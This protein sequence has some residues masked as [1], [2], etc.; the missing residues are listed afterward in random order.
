MLAGES[1]PLPGLTGKLVGLAGFEPTTSCT[2][3]KRTTKLC[4]SPNI[5]ANR[6]RACGAGGLRMQVADEGNSIVPIKT[7]RGDA[8]RILRQDAASL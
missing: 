6:V 7:M 5:F 1:L 8:P 3:C 2:P 4:Y